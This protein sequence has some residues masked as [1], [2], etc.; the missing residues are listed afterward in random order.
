MHPQK[1]DTQPFTFDF[2]DQPTLY[3]IVF[4]APIDRQ[5]AEIARFQELEVVSPQAS[6]QRVLIVF[7][8]RIRNLYLHSIL[9]K[10]YNFWLIWF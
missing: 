7:S 3:F 4:I 8:N 10:N 9:L 5:I 1:L 6:K 2:A